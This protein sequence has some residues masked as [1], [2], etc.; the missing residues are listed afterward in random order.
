MEQVNTSDNSP[1]H[2]RVHGDPNNQLGHVSILA[3]A[4]KWINP[5]Y[6]SSI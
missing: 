2:L 4:Y 1:G 5:D 3:I 6:E